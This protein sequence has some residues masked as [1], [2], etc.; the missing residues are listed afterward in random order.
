[1]LETT[2]TSLRY[3]KTKTDQHVEGKCSSKV[4]YIIDQGDVDLSLSLIYFI[5]NFI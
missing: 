3:L 1:M 2:N 5:H 4:P